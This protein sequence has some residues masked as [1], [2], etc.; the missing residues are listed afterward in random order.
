MMIQGGKHARTKLLN[1]PDHTDQTGR[2]FIELMR[3]LPMAPN[4]SAV[5]YYHSQSELHPLILLANS[6]TRRCEASSSQNLLHKC[7]IHPR[8]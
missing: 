5:E 6:K 4:G 2:V 8:T 7:S 3:D 1:W